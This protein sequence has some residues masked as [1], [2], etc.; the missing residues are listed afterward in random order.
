ML[1]SDAGPSIDPFSSRVQ[2]AEAEGLSDKLQ[3]FEDLQDFINALS[4]P[5]KVP[6]LRHAFRVRRVT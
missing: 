6:A 2:R 3:A 5:R 1:T 4:K